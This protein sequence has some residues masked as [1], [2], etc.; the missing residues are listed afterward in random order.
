MYSRHKLPVWYPL[1]C[2]LPTAVQTYQPPQQGT[3]PIL[4]LI[5]HPYVVSVAPLDSVGVWTVLELNKK[6]PE[7]CFKVLWW[8]AAAQNQRTLVWRCLPQACCVCEPE[9]L[10]LWGLSRKNEGTQNNYY[11]IPPPP[12]CVNGWETC[13]VVILACLIFILFYFILSSLV[14]T[15]SCSEMR[16][17]K[18]GWRGHTNTVEKLVCRVV[19]GQVYPCW[20]SSLSPTNCTVAET[21]AL[22]IW[23]LVGWCE[24]REQSR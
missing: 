5:T 4:D 10:I 12:R 6:L 3:V 19:C 13:T 9:P 18:R 20:E 23:E 8:I 24:R 2:S 7:F 22:H 21:F 14:P 17:G 15:H 11:A 16:R 1:D